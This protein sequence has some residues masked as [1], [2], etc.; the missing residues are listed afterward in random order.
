M[1]EKTR[2]PQIKVQ[3]DRIKAGA[4]QRNVLGTRPAYL[5]HWNQRGPKRVGKNQGTELVPLGSAPLFGL[6][7][8]Q[9]MSAVGSSEFHCIERGDFTSKSI[10]IISFS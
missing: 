3:A 2:A 1:S 4:C 5:S 10:F 7:I 9:S 8:L 6:L